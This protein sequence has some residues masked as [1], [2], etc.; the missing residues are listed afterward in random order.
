MRLEEYV[1]E[2]VEELCREHKYTRYRLAKLTGLSQ[3]AIGNIIKK[4]TLPTIPNLEKICDAF[5]ISLAQFFAGEGKWPGLSKVQ[6][7]LVQTWALL[8]QEERR[9]LLA[10]IRSL[11]KGS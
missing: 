5:G 6:E 8:D 9:I 11:K 1:A 4:K 7:E 10:F 3:T 2:R